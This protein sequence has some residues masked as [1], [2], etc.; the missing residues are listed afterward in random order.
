MSKEILSKK[1]IPYF[2][3]IIAIDTGD[4]Y[5]YEVLGRYV[6]DDGS[7]KSLGTF[8]SDK[9]V[10]NE[11]VL[12]IDQTVRRQALEQYAREGVQPYL[13]INL[14]LEWITK[15]ADNLEELP[16]I[17]WAKEFGVDTRKLVIEI[18]EEEFNIDD[19]KL[20]KIINHYKN[21]GCRIA[22]DDF[23]TQA[24]NFDRLA[25]LSPNI[26][27]I[28]M[29][30]VQKSSNSYYYLEYLNAITI[31]AKQVGIEVLYEGVETQ[32]QL[33]TCI[34]S[35][36]RYYQGFLLAKPQP[37]MKGAKVNHEIFSVSLRRSIVALH[38]R[39][40][41]FN[42]LRILLD[43]K[44]ADFFFRHEFNGSL[45][46][47]DDYLSKLFLEMEDFVKRICVCNRYGEQMSHN[48]EF[49]GEKIVWRGHPGRNWAWR[50]F[51]QEAT[52]L[53]DSG[54][55]SHLTEGYRDTETKEEVCTYSYGINANLFL[56][57]D[58]YKSK[59]GVKFSL[60]KKVK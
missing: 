53:L 55:K 1:I 50:S 26:L 14:R 40:A 10:S 60:D 30:Y 34:D 57:I 56:F 22:I 2:Q 44:M 24:S 18:T 23:G 21:N 3:P 47:I 25:L 48:I 45:D 58:I 16:T 46:G 42:T 54:M 7:V 12:R 35:K 13:F 6:D 11:D 36:G 39:V 52:I 5:S 38:E 51:F 59:A 49:Y 41:D 32:K 8:F 29:N 15:Y 17:A 27:K 31:L 9:T 37:V 20:T 4:I 43:H 19:D 33:D 28:S